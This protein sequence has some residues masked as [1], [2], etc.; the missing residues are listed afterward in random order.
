M[1]EE[2]GLTRWQVGT[3]RTEAKAEGIVRIAIT[4]RIG[5]MTALRVYLQCRFG[6]VSY[7]RIDVYKRQLCR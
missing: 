4:P 7:T 6:R 3:L 2:R 5:R 1:A